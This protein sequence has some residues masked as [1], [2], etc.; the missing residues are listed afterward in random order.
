MAMP[1]RTLDPSIYRRKLRNILRQLREE[2]HITQR[3]AADEM[4]WSLSKLIRIESGGVTISVNDL[5]A[6]LQFYDVTEQS[7]IN[8]LV[9][10]A[11]SSRLKSSWLT[12]Y[13]GIATE[14]YLSFLAH[15]DA[16]VR[17][18]SFQP[19][20]VPGLLQ[21]EAYTEAVLRILR[22]P[23]DPRRLDSL[24]E[25]RLA[26]QERFLA[27]A[28]TIKLSFLLDES[29]VRRVVGSAEV[30]REQVRHLLDLAQ[31]GEISVQVIP[32]GAGIY[33][34]I[35]V[36]FV[37]LES[38]EPEEPA[39]L[40]LEYPQGE[41]LIREDA[42]IEPGTAAPA[43]TTPTAPDAPTTPPTYLEIFSELQALTSGEQTI[44][45]LQGALAEVAR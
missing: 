16:A 34:S 23:K 35:R 24:L 27:R 39:V 26:R 29:V 30:M 44:Q 14:V 33:R 37:V 42:P 7:T 17:S 20:L 5:K 43:H 40:Y 6:L 2:R 21:T 13:R 12:A 38:G 4:S 10:M 32:F 9:E 28:G 19:V 8:E 18:S 31:R 15:E 45:I 36:P 22:G 11:R 1:E 3:A 41:Q 25:L